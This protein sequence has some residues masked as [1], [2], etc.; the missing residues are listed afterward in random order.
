MDAETVTYRRAEL[1]DQ[2]WKDPVRSVARSYGISDVWLAKLCRKL[3]VP[4]PGRGYWARKRA[5]WEAKQVPLS[6]IPEGKPSE[7]TVPRRRQQAFLRQLLRHGEIGGERPTPPRPNVTVPET[8]DNPHKLIAAARKL[9]RGREDSDGYLSCRDV[10]CINVCVTKGSLDRALRIMDAILRAIERLGYPVEVTRPLSQEEREY[11]RHTF[12]NVPDNATRVLVAGE[13][14]EFGISERLNSVRIPAEPPK[15][16]KG[17]ERESWLQSGYQTTRHMP[18]GA[19]ALK[20]TNCEYIGIR[21]TW[22]DATHQ[23]VDKCLGAFVAYLPI[24]AEAK[25][26]DRLEKE[27]RAREWEEEKRRK[28]EA[29]AR[30]QKEAEREKRLQEEIRDWRL[31]RDT[32]AYVAE[33]RALL[34][35]NGPV[36]ASSALLDDI[37]WMDAFAE[38]IDPVRTILETAS[39]TGGAAGSL[40]P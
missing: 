5:G 26:L 13:W 6:P 15:W 10:S 2:V 3:S 19:L 4:L 39:A 1:Y 16:I 7:I 29:R 28:E 24:A 30:A 11:Q 37:E 22:R 14:I 25:R 38:R 34:A 31:A 36:K 20:I 8:L 23:R 12:G 21:T 35:S 32:R 18:S 33:I 9:L 40:D 27:R 17:K